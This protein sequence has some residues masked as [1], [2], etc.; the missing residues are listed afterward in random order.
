MEIAVGY[1]FAWAV[2]K[3]RLVAG[4]ADA[5]VDRAVE[6]G[7]DRVHRVVSGKLGGDQALAQVEEEAGAEPAELAAETRQWLELSLNRAATR[8]AEFAAALVAAVQ[9]VQSAESAES[10]EGPRRARAAS[11]SAGT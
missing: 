10:A 1:V 7:M 2:R 9:A 6:A 8:D 4:R 5:E 3:A 11:R